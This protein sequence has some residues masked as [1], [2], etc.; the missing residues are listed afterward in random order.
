MF[1]ETAQVIKALGEP[2]RLRIIRFL[3]ERELCVCEIVAVMNMSQP[4]ISQH[5]KVL[6]QAGIV[7]ERRYRQKCYFSLKGMYAEGRIPGLERLQQ[8]NLL[9]IPELE[10]EVS[11]F[12]GLD[13]NTEVA[14]CK[15]ADSSY[16]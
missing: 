4:R 2:T 3:K 14:A 5:M 1:A 16:Q 11:R 13:K 8:E 10:D 7:H 9:N 12:E 15:G 6:K